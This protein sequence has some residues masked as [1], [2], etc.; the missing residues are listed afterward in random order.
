MRLAWTSKHYIAQGAVGTHIHYITPYRNTAKQEGYLPVKVTTKMTIYP[1]STAMMPQPQERYQ[2][3]HT[4]RTLMISSIY[5]PGGS[6]LV[7][8][9]SR[10][11]FFRSDSTL[12]ATPG[13]WIFIAT[14]VPSSSCAR[15][16][17][18]VLHRISHV[19]RHDVTHDPPAR[20][21]T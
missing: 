4:I 1:C 3:Y 19:T 5:R 20:N 17:C 14:S 13:Y 18:H 2:V 16:T 7:S 15:C 21:G 12:S 11:K 10:C 8:C 6:M 9:T